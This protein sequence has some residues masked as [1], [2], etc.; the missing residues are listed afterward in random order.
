MAETGLGIA[1]LPRIA[2]P[3]KTLL[4]AVRITGPAMSRTIT[5]ITIRGHSQSPAAARLVDFCD[6]SSPHQ[7][8][9]DDPEAPSG[10]SNL[11][12]EIEL[13]ITLFDLSGARREL[14][15]QEKTH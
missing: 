8:N 2:I 10:A 5:V 14:T 13:C 6:K 7:P 3:R 1:V 15:A 12:R 11:L 9:V 4:K